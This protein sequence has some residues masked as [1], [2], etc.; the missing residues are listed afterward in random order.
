MFHVE[1][2]LAALQHKVITLERYTAL[3]SEREL[4]RTFLASVIARL[5]IGVTGLAILLLVQTSSDS[6]ARGGAAAAFY[7]I[8]LAAI[9]PALG[10]GIDRYGPRR[11]LLAS[12]VL[13]PLRAHLL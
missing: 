2:L 5:P 6:F 8:G 13:F 3:F 4:R 12:G 7:V 1:P 10:R 9:A 11:L